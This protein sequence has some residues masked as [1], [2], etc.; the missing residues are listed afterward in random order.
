M[1][2]M[3]NPVPFH[4]IARAA[5]L[6]DETIVLVHDAFAMGLAAGRKE[7]FNELREKVIDEIYSLLERLERDHDSADA[8]TVMDFDM[9]FAHAKPSGLVAAYYGAAG[10]TLCL[11]LEAIRKLRAGRDPR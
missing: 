6:G 5:P 8:R 2:E 11:A 7:G 10:D 1:D 9:V 3:T 4:V